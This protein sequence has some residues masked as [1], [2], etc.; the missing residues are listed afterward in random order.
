MMKN[1]LMMINSLRILLD[2]NSS[3]FMFIS[4]NWSKIMQIMQ[5]HKR[6]RQALLKFQ[7]I[8]INL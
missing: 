2:S 5:M 4:I 8:K 6:K 7:E 1:L 3:S